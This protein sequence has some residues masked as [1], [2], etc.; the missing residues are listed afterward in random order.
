MASEVAYYTYMYAKVD[1]IHYQKVTGHTRSAV[2]CG[3][4][5]SGVLA[6][7]LVSAHL[8]NFRELNY[9][10]FACKSHNLCALSDY[11]CHSI[12]AYSSM[13]IVRVCSGFAI[14]KRQHVFLCTG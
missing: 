2:L 7:I 10:T 13:F 4:F 6:Q 5:M 3:R 11:V 8:M 14:G 1:K 12:C 9:V